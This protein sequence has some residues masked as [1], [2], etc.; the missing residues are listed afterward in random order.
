M[1]SENP[2]IERPKLYPCKNSITYIL[3]KEGMAGLKKFREKQLAKMR[4]LRKE[5]TNHN[6]NTNNKLKTN[7]ATTTKT[8][9]SSNQIVYNN[10]HYN[11]EPFDINNYFLTPKQYLALQENYEPNDDEPLDNKYDDYFGTDYLEFSTDE[12]DY[13]I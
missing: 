2:T 12:S 6:P 10:D 13:E 11:E 7:L 9:D 5:T 8:P 3:H 4:S 1:S